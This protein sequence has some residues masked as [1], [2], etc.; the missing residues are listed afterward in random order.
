MLLEIAFQRQKADFTE[1]GYFGYKAEVP[2]HFRSSAFFLALTY[3]FG[4]VFRE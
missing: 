4:H 2:T 1:E 3:R